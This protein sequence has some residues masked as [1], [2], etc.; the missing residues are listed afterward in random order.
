MQ[1]GR[2][3]IRKCKVD[4]NLITSRKPDD[5][6]AFNKVLIDALG[7][8]PAPQHIST[9][10]N[11]SRRCRSSH[12]EQYGCRRLPSL[13]SRWHGVVTGAAQTERLSAADQQ[14]NQ[15]FI[16]DAGA[17]EI[18]VSKL[19]LTNSSDKQV[20]DFA[21]RMIVD[22]TK[23]AQSRRDRQAPRHHDAAVGGFVG[24]RQFAESQGRRVR[25]GLH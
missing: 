14:F 10:A 18:A 22:H 13:R 4:D 9:R 19:A 12:S 17:T 5:L 8:R 16:Q 6:P 24:D 20:K 21:Q 7:T 23:R 2:G 11:R 3:S 25:Q 15:Q 1:A